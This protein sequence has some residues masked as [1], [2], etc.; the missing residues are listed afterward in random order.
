MAA[1]VIQ[2]I[3]P[4]FFHPEDFYLLCTAFRSKNLFNKLL[5]VLLML[6]VRLLK[7]LI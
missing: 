3:K 6:D 4:E 5:S 7:T 1:R 2:R